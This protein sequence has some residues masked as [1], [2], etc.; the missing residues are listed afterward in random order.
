[1]CVLPHRP[2]GPGYAADSLLEEALAQ[3]IPQNPSKS[4]TC[5]NKARK[6]NTNLQQ[7]TKR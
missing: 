7:V 5:A 3:Q 6:K 1:M 4:H 2:R